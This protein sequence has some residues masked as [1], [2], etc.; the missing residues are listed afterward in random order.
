[1]KALQIDCPA[2][3]SD[4]NYASVFEA[5]TRWRFFLEKLSNLPASPKVVEL[6][7]WFW[8]ACAFLSVFQLFYAPAIT[9]QS[10]ACMIG[11]SA[12]ALGFTFHH[13]RVRV[14]AQE[15]AG[16]ES[17]M[18]TPLKLVGIAALIGHV[19]LLISSGS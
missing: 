2:E 9:L 1:M 14:A 16:V 19:A 15:A 12:L 6:T 5:P 4:N 13:Q 18:E 17:K 11:A 7:M 10:F 3:A 8:K